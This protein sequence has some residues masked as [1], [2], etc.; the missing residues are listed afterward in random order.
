MVFIVRSKKRSEQ[1]DYK[2]TEK[3]NGQKPKDGKPTETD[4]K[5]NG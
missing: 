1:F 5:K 4:R 3:K 2:Q